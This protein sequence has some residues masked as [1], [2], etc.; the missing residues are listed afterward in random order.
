MIEN[1]DVRIII[2]TFFSSQRLI[3][4]VTKTKKTNG[5]SRPNL[6][7]EKIGYL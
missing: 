4:V 6:N 3:A 5:S 2:P 1:N 7:T